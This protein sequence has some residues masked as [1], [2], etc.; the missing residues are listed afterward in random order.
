MTVA[1]AIEQREYRLALSDW[2]DATRRLLVYSSQWNHFFIVLAVKSL[3]II[4]YP[5]FSL[6]CEA[7]AWLYWLLLW[8]VSSSQTRLDEMS[9]ADST[10]CTQDSAWNTFSLLCLGVFLL[11]AMLYR[12][13]FE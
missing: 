9:A 4:A 7:N 5:L 2:W 6:A 12:R 10:R 11:V 1:M 8:P 3:A 13:F